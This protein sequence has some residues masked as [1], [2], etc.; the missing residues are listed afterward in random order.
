[1]SS[2]FEKIVSHKIKKFL[3]FLTSNRFIALI[4]GIVATGLLQ[5]SS[6]TTLIVIGL[7]HSNLIS[8]YQAIPVIMGANIGT[9]ITSQ[10][11]AYNISSLVPYFLLIGL[12]LYI[13]KS[14]KYKVAGRVLISLGLI[15]T[16]I[17]IISFSITPIKHS[18]FFISL[19][20][21]VDNSKAIGIL[22]GIIITAIIQSSS[23]GV[24][25]LQ[26]MADKGLLEVKTVIPVIL[27]QNIG[28]C[29][30]TLIGSLATN[31]T[32]K[33]AAVIHILFNILGVVIFYFLIDYLY[34]IVAILS[35]SNPSRQ[36]AN[37]HT[38][39]NVATTIILLPLSSFIAKIAK[40]I[41]RD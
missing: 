7:V 12:L 24:T 20:S 4:T 28:T 18:R 3:S 6:A 13:T 36:V 34:N 9:T 11:V 26:V 19:I 5:S 35:P 21:Y 39:F 8:L 37:A 25:M 23:T 32:G 29:V 2:S 27:G 38:I 10:L 33:Q 14:K 1:M 31:R 40:K 41:V 15:F 22:T 17:E 16:G 30:D